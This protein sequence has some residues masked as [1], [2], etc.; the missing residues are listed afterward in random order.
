METTESDRKKNTDKQRTHGLLHFLKVFCLCVAAT[1]AFGVA[2]DQ[3][4]TRICFEYFS[5]GFHKTMIEGSWIE[6]L[7]Q[8]YPGNC[9]VWGIVWGVFASWWVGAILGVFLGL[10]STAGPWPRLSLGRCTALAVACVLLTALTVSSL[11]AFSMSYYL[12]TI[13]K[14]DVVLMCGLYGFKVAESAEELSEALEK[15]GRR[16]LLCGYIHN[17]AYLFGE[18]YGIC[19]VVLALGWRA[20][21]RYT[22]RV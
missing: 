16:Y 18:L 10:A 6:R 5:E 7:L 4:T 19:L 22:K 9:T 21:V 13:D 20:Y 15:I 17:L 2:L 3:F 14:R 11:G 8:R 12:D 1:C